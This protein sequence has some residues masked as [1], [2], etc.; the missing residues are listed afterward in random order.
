MPD[1]DLPASTATTVPSSS[2]VWNQSRRGTYNCDADD[3]EDEALK[4][5]W[6]EFDFSPEFSGLAMNNQRG[7]DE[8]NQEVEDDQMGRP[9]LA[10]RKRHKGLL[11]G[12]TEFN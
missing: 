7:V 10:S 6:S 11:G 9:V 8:I 3:F 1:P 12:V 5:F 4:D 2:S